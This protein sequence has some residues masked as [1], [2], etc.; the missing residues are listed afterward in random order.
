MQTRRFRASISGS[1]SLLEITNLRTGYGQGD[2]LFDVSLTVPAGKSVCLL[3]KN[4]AGKSTLMRSII[5]LLRK[6]AG[7]IEY[8]GQDIGGYASDSIS[9]AGIGYV[10]EDRGIFAKLTVEENLRV[11][12]RCSSQFRTL[13]EI[14]EIFPILGERRRQLGGTLSG[15]EQQLLSIARALMGGPNLLLLD[16]PSEG[17]APLVIGG[18]IDD[19]LKLK[20][21]G[22]TILFAEQN[23]EF[24]R[25]ISDFVYVID[26]GEIR[27]HGTFDALERDPELKRKHMF[28]QRRSTVESNCSSTRE[29]PR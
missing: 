3:G 11:T 22:L 23:L 12:R 17:L 18:L 24:A 14:Y 28:V 2:V 6:S 10:P 19:I 21:A 8:R 26:K 15:G 20:R 27:F 9:R 16:E 4:G 1:R 29:E 5:G 13:T 7:T 25:R